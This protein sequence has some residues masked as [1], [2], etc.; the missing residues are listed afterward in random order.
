MPFVGLRAVF[1]V[2]LTLATSAFAEPLGST[3][4][5]R[6]TALELVRSLELDGH[7]EGGFFR[8][9]YASDYTVLT[10]DDGE[11]LSMSSIFYLLAAESPCPL[12]RA[13]TVVTKRP[14][15][16]ISRK[17]RCASTKSGVTGE[18]MVRLKAA[19]WIKRRRVI[20][21]AMKPMRTIRLERKT[22][23]LKP[24][25]TP[26]LAE[27]ILALLATGAIHPSSPSVLFGA[28]TA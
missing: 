26:G 7:V 3:S 19:N 9:T 4:T 25:E 23:T 28:V 13:N 17:Q 10:A 8:R 18:S 2:L 15:A 24:I 14:R 22:P 5:S 20:F 21:E 12:K 1:G 16:M 11:R 6:L 27:V